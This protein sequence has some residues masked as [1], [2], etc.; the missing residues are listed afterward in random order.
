MATSP[1]HLSPHPSLSHRGMKA[2]DIAPIVLKSA[3]T[4]R[5]P[6]G[7]MRQRVWVVC[8]TDAMTIQVHPLIAW[9]MG[10]DRLVKPVAPI[11]IHSC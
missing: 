2:Q 6:F 3:D 4:V 11:W 10:I 1:L 7:A 8:A 9:G 5:R